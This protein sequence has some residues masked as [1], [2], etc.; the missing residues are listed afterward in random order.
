MSTKNINEIVRL[1]EFIYKT[2]LL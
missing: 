2:F 1:S